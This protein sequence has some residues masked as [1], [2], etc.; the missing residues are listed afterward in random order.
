MDDFITPVIFRKFTDLGEIIALFPT[1]PG[2]N[3]MATCLSY[4]HVG[5]H[6]SCHVDV[7][8]GK[9]TVLATPEE[10][11]D[12]YDELTSIGYNL[13][14]YKRMTSKQWRER[15]RNLHLEV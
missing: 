3:T 1:L 8:D 9:T 14:I 10:Y 12:L 5:Q 7:V 15:L 11:K 2:D 6:G 4:A 13:K